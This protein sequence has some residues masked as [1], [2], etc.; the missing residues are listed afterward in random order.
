MNVEK[1][2]LIYIAK[3]HT[4]RIVYGKL[5][6]KHFRIYRVEKWVWGAEFPPVFEEFKLLALANMELIL[7]LL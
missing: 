7:Y 6:N 4:V 5:I 1:F 3:Y 2:F